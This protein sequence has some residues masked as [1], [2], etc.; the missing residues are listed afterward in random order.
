[1]YAGEAM[2]AQGASHARWKQHPG[3]QRRRER[4]V[5]H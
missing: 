3:L 5:E 4:V 1:V 2:W